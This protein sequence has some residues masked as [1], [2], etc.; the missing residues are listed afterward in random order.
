MAPSLLMHAL[1]NVEDVMKNTE[2]ERLHQGHIGLSDCVH[3]DIYH[4]V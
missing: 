2:R 4:L 1:Y 3:V